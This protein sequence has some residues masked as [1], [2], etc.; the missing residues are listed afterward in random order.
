[1]KR[2]LLLLVLA[3]VFLVPAFGQKKSNYE[4]KFEFDHYSN[5][6]LL[7]A[8]FY[9]DKQLIKDTILAQPGKKFTY[10]GTDTLDAGIYILMFFPDKKYIQ[11]IIND[12]EKFFTIRGDYK[13]LSSLKFKGS[14]DNELFYTYMDFLAEKREIADTL[15][16]H[17][18]KAVDSRQDTATIDLRLKDLEMNVLAYQN[19]LVQKNPKS[20]TALMLLGNKDID[21]PELDVPAEELQRAR[22]YYY[23]KHFFDHIDFSN[24][25][26]IRTPFLH[27]KIERYLDQLTVQ[28]PDTI[29]QTIDD[30][31]LKMEPAPETWKFYVSHFLNKYAKSLVIGMDAVYVHMVDQYYSKGRTTWVA[32]ETLEKIIDNA[33]KLRPTLLGKIAEDV[34]LYTEDKQPVRIHDIES[35]Y[36]VLFFWAPDCGHCKQ[37]MPDIVKFSEKF[38]DKGVKVVAV[39]TK[40]RDKVAECWD[41]VKEKNMGVFYYNLTDEL[42]R[43]RYH[44]KYDVRT[45]PKVFILDKDKKIILKNVAGEKLD[46]IMTE[47]MKNDGKM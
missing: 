17:R 44:V 40:G 46:E 33:E 15:N 27:N 11:F 28:I 41:F 1:M 32:K 26:L 4:L 43:S 25:A 7:L 30:L 9:G 23:R 42:Y 29:S 12:Q 2:N 22:F 31:L 45:T 38:K 16:A 3:I 39:C 19:D 37:S 8:Y 18:K 24:P 35:D 10:S 36:L 20:I 34:T 47:V 14:K 5:D 13:D 21:I 6:T